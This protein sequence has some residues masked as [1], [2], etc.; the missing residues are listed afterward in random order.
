MRHTAQAQTTAPTSTQT[1]QATPAP[2]GTVSPVP[3]ASQLLAGSAQALKPVHWVHADGHIS[4]TT[5][6]QATDLRIRGDCGN[7]N[8]T[9]KNTV[10]TVKSVR[11]DVSIRLT[12]TSQGKKTV[13]KGK[14]IVITTKG[15]ATL[16][17]RTG[18]SRAPWKRAK[19]TPTEAFVQTFLVNVCDPLLFSRQPA[20][21]AGQGVQDLQAAPDTLGGVPVWKVTATAQLGPNQGRASIYLDRAS[22]YWLRSDATSRNTQGS[23]T[24]QST[25]DFSNYGKKVTITPPSRATSTANRPGRNLWKLSFPDRVPIPPGGRFAWPRSHIG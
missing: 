23:S 3:D 17:T 15:R 8:A 12:T 11:G 6:G 13:F 7:L 24:S 25:F 18:G 10:V 22:L 16:W 4:A 1:P 14:V 20:S 5:S 21:G 9:I 19:M 2:T